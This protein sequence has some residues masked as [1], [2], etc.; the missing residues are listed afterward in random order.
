M[1]T[2]PS[3]KISQAE[4][5]AKVFECMAS[6]FVWNVVYAYKVMKIPVDM[7]LTNDEFSE[8]ISNKDVLAVNESM[9]SL[10]TNLLGLL[11][12]PSDIPGDEAEM[13]KMLGKSEN[14][15][16]GINNL[17]GEDEDGNEEE[18]QEKINMLLDKL[19]DGLLNN[20]AIAQI[21]KVL[22][23]SSV[24]VERGVG[25]QSQSPEIKLLSMLEFNVELQS[26]RQKKIRSLQQQVGPICGEVYSLNKEIYSLENQ[27]KALEGQRL[28]SELHNRQA[29]LQRLRELMDC[30][31]KKVDCLQEKLE[32]KG[33]AYAQ[34]MRLQ[35]ETEDVACELEVAR[36]LHIIPFWE[37]SVEFLQW[38][39]YCC[40]KIKSL[41]GLVESGKATEEDGSELAKFVSLRKELLDELI[42][43]E[44]SAHNPKLLCPY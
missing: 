41:E 2:E 26:R 42:A 25:P 19:D 4:A 37:L 6:Q 14:G 17:S 10:L 16:A 27:I 44:A 36:P 35:R 9:K 5:W 33:G 23:E 21:P 8:T 22:Y 40:G 1:S 31:Q 34:L 13:L 24:M 39:G 43:F 18:M 28:Y 11:K 32:G 20:N 3:E 38:I 30:H 12:F 29:K 7:H 15:E